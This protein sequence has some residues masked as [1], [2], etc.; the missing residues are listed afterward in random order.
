IQFN[1]PAGEVLPAAPVGARV[2][3]LA[4]STH[5]I[6]AQPA[7]AA[8]V[9]DPQM[10]NRGFFFVADAS[11][12]LLGP[13]EAVTGLLEVPGE[14]LAGVAVPR[15]AVLHFNGAVWVYVQ[16][17]EEGFRRVE[18]HPGPPLDNAL[19]VQEGLRAGDKLVTV[20]AQQ[21]LSEELKGQSGE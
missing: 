3:T 18:I 9:T 2:M 4:D 12:G 19:F 1:L 15:S 8:P 6:K 17:G 10:Q 20:G 7:G 16:T 14:P 5:P 11:A 21:L 13:G